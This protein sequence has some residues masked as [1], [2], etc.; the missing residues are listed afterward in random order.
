METTSVSREPVWNVATDPQEVRPRNSVAEHAHDT[1]SRPN[2]RR[3][4]S[5]ARRTQE[6][7][8]LDAS[9]K[10]LP[11]RRCMVAYS[12]ILSRVAHLVGFIHRIYR[13]CSSIKQQRQP[14]RDRSVRH[15]IESKPSLLILHDL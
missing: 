13:P 1:D 6:A 4:D 9:T 8:L 12:S 11:L 10:E 5:I 14:S 2:Q 3:R 7:H 15:S